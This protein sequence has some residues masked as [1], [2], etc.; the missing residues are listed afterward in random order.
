M[1]EATA[2]LVS[3]QV[4]IM[5][6]LIKQIIARRQAKGV[7]SAE[8]TSNSKSFNQIV[9]LDEVRETIEFPTFDAESLRR[10][11]DSTSI[12]LSNKVE[13]QL[14]SFVNCS[15]SRLWFLK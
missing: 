6:K 2:R 8:L 3:W 13:E 9:P 15:K 5:Q 7:S 1:N 14:C 10:E 11:P 4:Q 12:K